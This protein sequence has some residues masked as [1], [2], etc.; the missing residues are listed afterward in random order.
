MARVLAA[1]WAQGLAQARE[2]AKEVAWAG[3]SVLEWE[4]AW[5][6]AWAQ[7]KAQGLA[8]GLEQGLAMVSGGTSAVP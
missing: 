2:R 1:K 3:V 4:S 8:T 6:P 7:A 5:V